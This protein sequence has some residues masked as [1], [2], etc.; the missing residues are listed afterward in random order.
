MRDTGASVL[1]RVAVP[2]GD[3]VTTG[4]AVATV[5][6]VCGGDEGQKKIESAKN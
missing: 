5:P 4:Q 3:E 6:G 1:L 2:P